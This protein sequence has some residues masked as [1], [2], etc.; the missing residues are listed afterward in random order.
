MLTNAHTVRGK[1]TLKDV[2][3][4]RKYGLFREHM[5]AMKALNAMKAKVILDQHV[6]KALN[7]MKA[8][9]KVINNAKVRNY[10]QY[11][12]MNESFYYTNLKLNCSM[13]MNYN[14]GSNPRCLPTKVSEDRSNNKLKLISNMM[15]K[16]TLL[17]TICVMIVNIIFIQV[18]SWYCCATYLHIS[19]NSYDCD[20]FEKASE[21]SVNTDEKDSQ[22]ISIKTCRS[23]YAKFIYY[24][25]IKYN[26]YECDVYTS[27]NSRYNYQIPLNYH[28]V[29]DREPSRIP[30]RRLTR[31]LY[32]SR[33]IRRLE[34]KYIAKNVPSRFHQYIHTFNLGSKLYSDEDKRCLCKPRKHPHSM[35]GKTSN[36]AFN[37]TNT[38]VPQ[39]LN[40][41]RA[42]VSA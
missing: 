4:F 21:L 7:A 42:R 13:F 19:L 39:V 27:S 16:W 6:M 14:P 20:I 2:E 38:R 41:T 8:N 30:V 18:Y 9:A 15:V 3:R 1:S 11:V 33:K 35:K 32:K 28:A 25:R 29:R 36:T 26:Y 24:N 5:K 17:C 12:N 34:R 37:K 31:A 40:C 23:R 10:D 22:F